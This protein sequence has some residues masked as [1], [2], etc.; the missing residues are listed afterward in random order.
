MEAR[1][2]VPA[3]AACG[4]R[5]GASCDRGREGRRYCRRSVGPPKGPACPA[6]LPPANQQQKP[7][8]TFENHPVLTRGPYN[9]PRQSERGQGKARKAVAWAVKSDSESDWSDAEEASDSES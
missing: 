8:H 7:K 2:A 5:A 9:R 4:V 6:L 3:C 1:P